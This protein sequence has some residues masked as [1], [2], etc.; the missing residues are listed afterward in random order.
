MEELS[1]DNIQ[2]SPIT[3]RWIQYA[4]EKKIANLT[5][6]TNTCVNGFT[7]YDSNYVQNFLLRQKIFGKL[8]MEN[9][10]TCLNNL[11]P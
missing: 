9:L 2:N 11:Q 5:A 10:T 6:Y 3:S 7:K 8:V 1:P 4:K